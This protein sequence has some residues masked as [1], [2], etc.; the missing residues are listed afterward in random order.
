MSD[1]KQLEK[2][3]DEEKNSLLKEKIRLKDE[4]DQINNEK[5]IYKQKADLLSF[6]KAADKERKI[7]SELLLVESNLI[8]VKTKVDQLQ[9]EKDKLERKQ[10]QKE[11]QK[12]IKKQMNEV[13]R[14]VRQGKTRSE[15]AGLVGIKESRILNWYNEGKLGTNSNTRY[16]YDEL[17]E[18]EKEQKEKARKERL[19]KQ[20]RENIE[21][22]IK[23]NTIN[24]LMYDVLEQM[25]N[26]KNRQQAAQ[27]AGVKVS[28]VNDWYEKGLNN[29]TN[30]YQFYKK[31]NEIESSQKNSITEGKSNLNSEIKI[32]SIP[33]IAEV[34]SEV[35]TQKSDALVA[36]NYCQNCGK[37][38]Y[39]DESNYCTNC[40]SSLI[41]IEKSYSNGKNFGSGSKTTVTTNNFGKCCFGQMVIFVVIAILIVII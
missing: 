17:T 21:N 10:K 19:I 2:K 4:L 41:E 8:S 3:Y 34:K 23:Q 7:N 13:L 24:D 9:K 15:A 40:G 12:Q 38:L 18:I 32:N 26:G 39:G 35:S 22:Q 36:V 5:I 11:K 29:E 37:K 28:Q 14:Y 31:V 25:Q 33:T 16:F 6:N 1:F 20:K 30:Y 27:I